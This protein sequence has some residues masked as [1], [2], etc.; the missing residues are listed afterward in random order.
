MNPRSLWP[1]VVL[2]SV[3]AIVGCI[4]AVFKVPSDV[5]ALVASLMIVPVLTALVTGQISELKGTTSQLTT[6]TNG[7]WSKMIE[8]L[9]QAQA[10]PTNTAKPPEP[11]STV[12]ATHGNEGS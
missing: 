11:P 9:A 3:G 4:M 7:N 1:A 6:Q 2:A 5:I 8:L 12:E 10:L